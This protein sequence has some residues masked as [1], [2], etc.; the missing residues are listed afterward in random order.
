MSLFIYIK[1]FTIRHKDT[2]TNVVV[3]YDPIIKLNIAIINVVISISI[4]R[5]AFIVP[6]S[7]QIYA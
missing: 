2:Q 4:W 6:F 3:K 7:W 5:R 1:N